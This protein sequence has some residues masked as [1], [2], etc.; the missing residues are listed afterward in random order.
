MRIAVVTL[1]IGEAPLAFARYSHPTFR[2]YA[3]RVDAEFVIID[4]ARVN[5]RGE[6]SFN[7]LLFEKY[8]VGDLLEVYDRILYLD[9]DI[10][11]TPHAP[12]IFEQVPEDKVGGVFED[13]GMDTEDRRARIRAVQEDLGDVGWREG[14]MNSGV[15]VVS[16]A[17]REAFRLFETCGVH[18]SKYEQTCT[19]WYFRKAGY[20]VVGLDYRFNYMGIMRVFHGPP[21]RGAYFIHYAGGGIFPGIPRERQMREDYEYFYGPLPGEESLAELLVP[22]E[23]A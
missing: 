3:E 21:H 9:T 19:N 15:F 22:D 8:Q 18:D 14:F 20:E 11:V 4:E 1:C 23:K 2:R 5:F 16:R 7:P 12:D 17:H 10:L 6:V 13:F